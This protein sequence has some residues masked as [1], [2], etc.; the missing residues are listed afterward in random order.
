MVTTRSITR[1]AANNAG[2]S[3]ADAGPNVPSNSEAP[4]ANNLTDSARRFFTPPPIADEIVRRMNVYDM[5]AAEASKMLP[6]NDPQ[7][8][9]GAQCDEL[10]PTGPNTY[11]PCTTGPQSRNAQVQVCDQEDPPPEDHGLRGH[12]VCDACRLRILAEQNDNIARKFPDLVHLCKTCTEGYRQHPIDFPVGMNRCACRNDLRDDGWKCKSCYVRV[13]NR[14]EEAANRRAQDLL[15]SHRVKYW[16]Q[17]RIRHR[18][19]MKANVDRKW[20]ACPTPNC[21]QRPW[22]TRLRNPGRTIP[23]HRAASQCMACDM[24]N[25][26]VWNRPYT[27]EVGVL[28]KGAVLK[29]GRI[30]EFDFSMPLVRHSDLGVLAYCTAHVDLDPPPFSSFSGDSFPPW[31]KPSQRSSRMKSRL[32]VLL[33]LCIGIW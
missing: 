14:R 24:V 32:A 21:G 13:I 8:L 9:L 15:F 29:R 2:A 25:I 7:R 12:N 20:P 26:P 31:T 19:V 17:G 27:L 18:V 16:D 23:H 6:D 22:T 3:N 28:W 1:A 33:F 5:R 30:A 10:V 4:R 11:R